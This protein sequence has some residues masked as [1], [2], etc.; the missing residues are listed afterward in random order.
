[1]ELTIKHLA[2]YLPYGVKIITPNDY[3]FYGVKTDAKALVL[4]GLKDKSL[5]FYG[6]GGFYPIKH[7]KPILRPLSDLTKEIEHNGEK[8]VPLVE[9]AKIVGL[10]ITKFDLSE[11]AIAYGLRCNIENDDDDDKYKVLGFD[12]FNGFGIHYRPSKSWGI[13][14][15]Q[16]ELWPKLYEWHFDIF[17]LIENNLAIDINTI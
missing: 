13:V 7:F 16:V 15:N 5:N 4:D 11:T 12:I 10:D 3:S 2:A 6:M 14:P 17:G 8:F 9:L 1:M